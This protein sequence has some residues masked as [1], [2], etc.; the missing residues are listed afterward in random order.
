MRQTITSDSLRTAGLRMNWRRGLL[1]TW[2]AASPL[3]AVL[4]VIFLTS[5]EQLPLTHPDINVKWGDEL[6]SYPPTS[7]EQEILAD[8]QRRIGEHQRLVDKENKE[9]AEIKRNITP[10]QTAFCEAQKNTPFGQSPKYCAPWFGLP[11]IYEPPSLNVDEIRHQIY[12]SKQPLL[13]ESIPRYAMWILS[14]PILV[15]LGGWTIAWVAR[16]FHS[17]KSC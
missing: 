4:I 5:T 7:T 17:Q 11:A 6:I 12:E 15:L 16:G 10:E 13:Q 14:P 9:E 8:I 1:R 3:W 2:L